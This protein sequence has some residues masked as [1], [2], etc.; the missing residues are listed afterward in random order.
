[1]KQ[2]TNILLIL[3]FIFLSTTIN[4]SQVKA[5]YSSAS[6]LVDKAV[7]QKSFYYYNTAY[8]ETMEL[9]NENEKNELLTKLNSISNEVWNDNVKHTNKLL[10][11]MVKT[12]SGRIYDEIEAYINKSNMPDI[13]KSYFLSELTSWGRKLIWT[14][15]Y[16]AA[17]DSI[18][19]AYEKKDQASAESAKQIINKVANTNSKDYLLEQLGY[20]KITE[21]AQ[22]IN[23]DE[24]QYVDSNGKGLIKGNI[25]SS[26]EKIYHM[27]G[28]AYYDRTIAEE[29]FITES[30]AKAA[31]Y[32]RSLR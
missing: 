22:P 31:G 16:K 27:P 14:D 7:S 10:E 8:A 2:K 4:I 29:Y 18:L 5:D 26:K 17:M 25:S 19:S 28:G 20:I 6:N 23:S 21:P 1:M 13:D 24:P 12:A 30:E 32:R 9:K 3:V 15:E 11:D